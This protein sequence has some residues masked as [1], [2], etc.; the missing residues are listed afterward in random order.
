MSLP[1][2]LGFCRRGSAIWPHVGL[3]SAADAAC[4][5]MRRRSSVTGKIRSMPWLLRAS[6]GAPAAPAPALCAQAAP[7]G[8]WRRAAGVAASQH[9]QV[10]CFD[11]LRQILRLN[12]EVGQR[13]HVEAGGAAGALVAVAVQSHVAAAHLD[14]TA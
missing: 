8:A 13:L 1:A 11:Q 14:P 7:P 5:T 9:L 4:S 10:D 3:I 2:A 6:R 12:A